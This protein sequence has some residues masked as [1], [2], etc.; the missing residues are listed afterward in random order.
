MAEN[1]DRV[2]K[3]KRIKDPDDDSIFV[4]IPVLYQA[5]F[6][7]A[8]EQNQDR[9][10]YLRNDS[11]SH[12]ETRVRTVTNLQT[13]DHVDCERIKSFIVKS[14]ADQ[15]QEY[16]YIL[17]NED[18]PPIQPDGT[19]TPSH[20]RRHVVRFYSNNDN[21]SEKWV[22]LELGDELKIISAAEQ[23]Q[24]YRVILRNPDL[25]NAVNDSTVFYDVTE[26]FCDTS[27]DLAPDDSGLDPPYR[28]DPFSNIVNVHWHE[29]DTS[30]GTAIVGALFGGGGP[31]V[32]GHYNLIVQDN[33]DF[34]PHPSNPNGPVIV[35]SA[36]FNRSTHTWSYNDEQTFRGT[37]DGAP[38][39][40]F[41]LDAFQTMTFVP[42]NSSRTYVY[43]GSL[44]GSTIIG[45]NNTFGIVL[46]FHV[47]F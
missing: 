17:K 47:S 12:R 32:N 31:D 2:Y 42:L 38:I 1:A 46:A 26:G 25:G 41:S 29:A 35:R 14:I 34:P 36:V 6:L 7:T 16:E 24:E 11:S 8:A 18:P 28:L 4:D 43:D 21:S 9:W 20:E 27:F 10:M 22:D 30:Q 39:N 5:K 13:G 33:P 23:Y 37:L 15:A 3:R 40:A 44:S 45:D 19:N